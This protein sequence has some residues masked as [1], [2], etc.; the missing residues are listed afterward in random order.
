L[1][2]KEIASNLLDLIA[3]GERPVEGTLE[4]FPKFANRIY[5]ADA[6]FSALESLPEDV[7]RNVIPLPESLLKL[8]GYIVRV[9]ISDEA[10]S[11]NID[12]GFEIKAG[13]DFRLVLLSG[14]EWA[15]WQIRSI[16]E[17]KK[18]N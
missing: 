10:V 9:G 4:E 5:P 16:L 6:F 1:K 8:P 2:N 18:P 14:R 3:Q 17:G 7:R 11:G 15:V 12:V 13:G